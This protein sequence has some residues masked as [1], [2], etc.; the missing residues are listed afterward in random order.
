MQIQVTLLFIAATINCLLSLFVL[1]GKRDRTNI[2]Y[3][4]FVLFASFWAIGLAFFII[5]SDLTQVIYIADFYYISALGIPTFFLYFSLIFLNKDF[6]PYKKNLFIFLPLITLTCLFI[7]DKNLLIQKVFFTD[8]GK[9]VLIN[10]TNY[11]IYGL[12]FVIFVIFSYFNLVKSY[13]L[14]TNYEEKNQLKLILWGTAIGFLFGMI[15]DLILPF[16][17]DYRHIFIGPIFSL[18]MVTSIAYSITKYRMFNMKVIVTQLLMVILWIFILVRAL[19]ADTLQE[20]MIDVVL[21]VATI[22]IGMFL[23]KSVLREV[24]QREK[25]ETLAQDLATANDRLKDLDQLKSEFLSL[26]TH[27]IRAPLTAI[28]GY[29]SLILEGDFGE[30]SESVRKPINII[31]SACENLVVIVG[32]FLNISRIEQGKMK[33]DLTDFDIVKVVEEVVNELKPNIEGSGLFVNFK[34]EIP[35]YIIHADMGKIKQVVGNLIDN[36][37]KYTKEGGIS[38]QV[39]T[40]EKETDKIIISI[41]DTGIGIAKEDMAKLFGKFVRARDAFRTNVV[42]TGLGLYVA[43]QMVE[44]QGGKIWIESPGVGKGSTFFVELPK[45]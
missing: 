26:A 44:A 35:S 21:L 20:Q 27:Q 16:I 5:E 32:D 31:L 11:I 19:L 34:S 39:K 25:I 30:V 12:F 17:G 45:K 37:I 7:V 2:I 41:S 18:F 13:L 43:K 42:G 9:D 23:I 24:S 1:L 15:F 38:L 4:V 14:K 6:K 8:W 29:A 33:Y 3:S 36:S 28:K 40:G 22:V 10:H